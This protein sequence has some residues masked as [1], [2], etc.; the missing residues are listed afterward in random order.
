[1]SQKS[2][3]MFQ[4]QRGQ[5]QVDDLSDL[6]RS[7][8]GTR[9]TQETGT[10]ARAYFSVESERLPLAVRLS[11]LQGYLEFLSFN[12]KDVGERERDWKYTAV[13]S[14]ITKHNFHFFVL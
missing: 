1:M 6:V 5:V 4:R 14:S 8:H 7:L 13:Y 11:V 10:K 12:A 9:T 2:L 3:D